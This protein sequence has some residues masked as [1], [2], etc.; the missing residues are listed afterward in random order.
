MAGGRI[1]RYHFLACSVTG[2]SRSSSRSIVFANDQYNHQDLPLPVC[3]HWCEV[4]SWLLPFV[5]SKIDSLEKVRHT[6]QDMKRAE[7]Q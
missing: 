5:R 4:V 7:D 6:L 2:R 1:S 3:Y